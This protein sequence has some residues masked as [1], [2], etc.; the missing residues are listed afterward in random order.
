MKKNNEANGTKTL[1][2]EFDVEGDKR[3]NTQKFEPTIITDTEETPVIKS[4]KEVEVISVE[5]ET[6]PASEGFAEIDNLSKDILILSKKIVLITDD[7][8]NL[9]A[10]DYAK[11]LTDLSKKADAARKEYNQPY[12]D[13]IDSNNEAYKL[14]L[15]EPLKIEIDRL[16]SAIS[17]YENEK[18]RK[19]K[20]AADKL[21]K[22]I[23]EKADKEEAERQRI[24][25][26]KLQLEKIKT[27]GIP[28]LEKCN[29]LDELNK[30]ETTVKG[31]NF[32]PEFFAEF[33]DDAQS[34]KEEIITLIGQRR[35]L[36]EE[37]DK[38]Q[39]EAELLQGEQRASAILE[40]EATKKALEE[41]QKADE[42]KRKSEKLQK[43]N[44]EL[45][46]RQ[47]IMTIVASFGVKKVD[48]Y[49]KGIVEK[50]GSCATAIADRQGLV[51][52][53]RESLVEKTKVDVIESEKIKNVRTDYVFSIINEEEIPREFLSVDESKI[54]KAIQANRPALEKD[55]NSF[56]IGGV[57]IYEKK[58]TIIK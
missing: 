44:K 58:S 42:E 3:E 7:I 29:T 23:K 47:E 26:I 37:I 53:Y 41:K 19:R 2:T 52:D 45:T 36:L 57:L 22:E 21:A 4:E 5:L 9:S 31:W 10:R 32:K 38:K 54:K 15:I 34:R 48:D 51:N 49:I 39:K 24:A 55:I 13:K 40:A 35:P 11:K 30:F 17:F 56:S 46:A 14:N 18:E 12:Q 1:F 50:Y 27:E 43:D 33:F 16:K 20:E 28:A 8:D 25:K 6:T